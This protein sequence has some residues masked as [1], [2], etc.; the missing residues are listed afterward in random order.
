MVVVNHRANVL[1]VVLDIDWMMK[2]WV[3]VKF[4]HSKFI[5]DAYISE[6]LEE[7]LHISEA[8][9]AKSRDREVPHSMF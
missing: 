7:N 5:Y 1:I 8:I 6:Q 4:H 2:S 3:E 9:L